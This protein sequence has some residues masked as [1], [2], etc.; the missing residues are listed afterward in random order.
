MQGM[1]VWSNLAVLLGS[2]SM[3]NFQSLFFSVI[4][5][6]V[7]SASEFWD[8]RRK[9]WQHHIPDCHI[10]SMGI[11]LPESRRKF[12]GLP[13]K[14]SQSGESPVIRTNSCKKPL[15]A[16]RAGENHSFCLAFAK[17]SQSANSDSCA[18]PWQ[19]EQTGCIPLLDAM[20]N[21]S[22]AH[23]RKEWH[24]EEEN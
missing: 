7:L 5:V 21:I 24:E 6:F 11:T 14:R 22:H 9:G 17:E 1:R 10:C 12:G 13:V 23:C 2:P 19:Q 4:Q 16:R 18:V 3:V 15:P 20:L 8:C